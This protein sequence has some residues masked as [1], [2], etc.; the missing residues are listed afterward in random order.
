MITKKD[1]ESNLSRRDYC[2]LPSE[3]LKSGKWM[4]ID[5][6]KTAAKKFYD[7]LIFLQNAKE[8]HKTLDFGTELICFSIEGT[9]LRFD[10]LGYPAIVQDEI[11]KILSL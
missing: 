4:K 3:T 9:I 2:F 8:I 1:I 10:Y 11:K 6:R 5:K 7:I